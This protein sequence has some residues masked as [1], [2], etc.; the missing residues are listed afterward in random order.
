M[1]CFFLCRWLVKLHLSPCDSSPT[2][3]S[4][5]QGRSCG[6]EGNGGAVATSTLSCRKSTTSPAPRRFVPGLRIPPAAHPAASS[7]W[8]LA[9]PVWN[10]FGAETPNRPASS[11]VHL[12]AFLRVSCALVPP[13]GDGDS[14]PAAL[15]P[16]EFCLGP[17]RPRHERL[18]DMAFR[19]PSRDA[20]GAGGAGIT[21]NPSRPRAARPVGQAGS[22]TPVT[23][24]VDMRHFGE[25]RPPPAPPGRELR[26]RGAG[27]VAG[28][29][30]P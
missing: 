18:F 22:P 30:S 25:P 13:R 15:R 19:P 11:S 10:G 21:L 2:S 28:S 6:G 9:R 27:G 7:G 23:N 17:P 26:G 1:L 8:R 14:G 29:R 16:L 24:S 5:T 3:T 20:Y 4:R 12:G